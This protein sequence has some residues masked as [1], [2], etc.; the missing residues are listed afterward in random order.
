MSRDV[1]GVA[2]IQRH[3]GV[4]YNHAKRVIDGL[5]SD[6]FIESNPNKPWQ[7]RLTWISINYAKGID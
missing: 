3:L 4:G 7:Y 2:S 6:G 5:L 1:I